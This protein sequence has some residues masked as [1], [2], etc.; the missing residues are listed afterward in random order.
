MS[1]EK[2]IY[3]D[4]VNADLTAQR[5]KEIIGR[6]SKKEKEALYLLSSHSRFIGRAAI[7]DPGLID[8]VLSGNF[9]KNRKK[10]AD[11]NSELQVI[12]NESSGE[13]DLGSRLR[14]YKYREFAR[15]I[16][17]DVALKTDFIPILEE[18]SDL[19]E[20]IINAVCT[21]YIDSLETRKHGQFFVLAMGKLGGRLLN[22]SSD[23]DLIYVFREKKGS[24]CFFKL[25]EKITK[26]IIIVF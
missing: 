25:S 13:D 15:V 26:M 19:A 18:L 3:P 20:S 11:Y 22:L 21:Y 8:S 23:V 10:L 6:A 7:S 17:K 2:I 14:I 9:L 5:Y 12:V 4:T 16:Y 24:D 1:K